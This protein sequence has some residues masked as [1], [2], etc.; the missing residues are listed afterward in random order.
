MR[1]GTKL[2][3]RLETLGGGPGWLRS[4]FVCRNRIE[5]RNMWLLDNPYRSHWR[6]FDPRQVVLP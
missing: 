2:E 5:R 6:Y 1:G 4:R 3:N